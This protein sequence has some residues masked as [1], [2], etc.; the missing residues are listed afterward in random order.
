MPELGKCPAAKGEYTAQQ[1][2][3]RELGWIIFLFGV[4]FATI[5]RAA[6][7]ASNIAPFF[8]ASF[9]ADICPGVAKIAAPFASCNFIVSS[10]AFIF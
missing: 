4:H 1:A 5:A 3:Q 8:D 2:G 6:K 7:A 9:A 10:S